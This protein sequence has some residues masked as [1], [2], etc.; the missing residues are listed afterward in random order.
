MMNI[1]IDFTQIPKQKVGVGVYALETFKR[2]FKNSSGHNYFCLVQN[3]D[4]ELITIFGS[5]NILKVKST[6]C[7]NFL[8]RFILE[9]SY[10]PYLC[11][12]YDIDI[13]H[14][15]HYSFPICVPKKTKRVV[16]IHD[17]TFFIYP[18]LHVFVK[19]YYFRFFI[20]LACRNV[21]S[22]ICV[23]NSTKEDL[24]KYV[25]HI[26]AAVEVIPLAATIP[27]INFEDI[28]ITK[29]KFR[30]KDKY[31]LFIGTLEPR[32]NI[33][34]LIKAYAKSNK[35]NSQ[36]QLVIVGKK[37]WYYQEIFDLLNL[38][39][40]NDKVVLTGFVS[41]TE[42]FALL[43][44][45]SL[46]VYPSIYEGFGLPVLESL[47]LGIPTITSNISSLPEVAGEA[48]ILID[49]TSVEILC[50]AINTCL[51]DG[52]TIE[53]LKRESIKQFGKFSWEET[54]KKT[55]QVYTNLK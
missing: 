11:K 52:E 4:E 22:V 12:K 37:G 10:I 35:V 23:S 32:K 6:L 42:K 30:I 34:T 1:L 47:G 15:L 27:Q 45:A 8:C 40:L 26:N 44:S 53:F 41:S 19:R 13:I 3:D 14:S 9:Q 51:F 20:K 7:R 49:P 17:L 38:L 50:H 28:C 2:L 43:S 48:A 39:Q 36:Y 46:F 18:K 29:S 31:I 55:I 21:N 54:A 16:T 5:Y 33:V 25:K 24:F